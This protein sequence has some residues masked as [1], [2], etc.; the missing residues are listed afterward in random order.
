MRVQNVGSDSVA[1]TLQGTFYEF[2]SSAILEFSDKLETEIKEIL[3]LFPNLV[4]VSDNAIV[5]ARLEAVEEAVISGGV[6]MKVEGTTDEPFEV[7]LDGFEYVFPSAQNVV[8]LLKSDSGEVELDTIGA[9]GFVGQITY[10]V[11]Q[12]DTDYVRLIN[13]A[14]LSINGAYDI[15]AKRTLQ[16]VWDGFKFIE[17]GRSL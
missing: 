14:L 16:L 3:K 5:E 11:G 9:G 10:L 12:D 8:F 4:I 2:K 17:L 1:F 7:S 13:G 15:T 6:G